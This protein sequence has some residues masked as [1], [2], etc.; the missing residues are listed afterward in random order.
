M[1]MNKHQIV[2]NKITKMNKMSVESGDNDLVPH[3]VAERRGVNASLCPFVCKQVYTSCSN[4]SREC[5][6]SSNQ[7]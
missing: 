4:C 6:D 1:Y 3:V 7:F 2:I 5:C